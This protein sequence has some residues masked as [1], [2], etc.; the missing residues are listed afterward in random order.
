MTAATDVWEDVWDRLNKQLSAVATE[1]SERNPHLWS[2][3]G[4]SENAAMPFRAWVSFNRRG[5]PGHEDIVISVDFKRVEHALE[6]T[7][8]IARGSGFVLAEAPPRRISM[9]MDTGSLREAILA[10]EQSTE[11]FISAHQP[12]LFQ[13]LSG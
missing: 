11:D 8:D 1:L 2:Q 4:H 10:A 12:L 9:T 3:A 7:A 6:V 5:I 13:E